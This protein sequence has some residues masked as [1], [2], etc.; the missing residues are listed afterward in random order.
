MGLDG[1]VQNATYVLMAAGGGFGAT[2]FVPAVRDGS[3]SSL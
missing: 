1:V 3:V 2:P